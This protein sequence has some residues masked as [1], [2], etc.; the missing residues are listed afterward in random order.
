M[1]HS[2]RLPAREGIAGGPL[3]N[4]EANTTYAPRPKDASSQD[5]NKDRE[6]SQE[7][8]KEQDGNKQ[9][10]GEGGDDDEEKQDDTPKP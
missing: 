3:D 8:D 6:D 9:G 5:S 2:H 4:S 10:E 7:T 1:V